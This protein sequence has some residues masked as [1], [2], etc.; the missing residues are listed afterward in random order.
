M[1]GKMIV[2]IISVGGERYISNF[3]GKEQDLAS[4]GE[5]ITSAGKLATWLLSSF[6][7]SGR[8]VPISVG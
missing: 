2:P 7:D 6:N 4:K 3:L 5:A 8:I 1:T